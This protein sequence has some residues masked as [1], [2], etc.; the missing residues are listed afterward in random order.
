[1]SDR[2]PTALRRRR[3]ALLLLALLGL[4][5]LLLGAY[6]WLWR[7]QDSPLRANYDRIR[8]GMTR[9]EVVGILGKPIMESAAYQMRL[10]FQAM[11]VEGENRTG[12][13]VSFDTEVS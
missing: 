6:F 11:W 12:V 5:P 4:P 8:V 9:E 3:R 1:M 13:T 10:P 2:P 7:G